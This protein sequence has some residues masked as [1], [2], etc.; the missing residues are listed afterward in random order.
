MRL[1][2]EPPKLLGVDGHRRLQDLERD[3]AAK[4]DLLG[5]V[6]HPHPTTPDFTDDSEVAEQ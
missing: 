1:Q 6:N 3:P 5:L 4:R 2:L